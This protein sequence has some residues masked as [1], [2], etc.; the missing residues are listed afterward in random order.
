VAEEGRERRR[1]EER[2]VPLEYEIHWKIWEKKGKKKK[3]GGGELRTFFLYGR[4]VS[5]GIENG[6]GGRECV[7]AREQQKSCA[8]GGV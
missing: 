3:R 2:M 6:R 8:G 5:A 7:R 1:R 4:E